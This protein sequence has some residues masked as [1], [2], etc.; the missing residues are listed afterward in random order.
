MSSW[1]PPPGGPL[2]HYVSE[3]PFDPNYTLWKASAGNL[4]G[5]MALPDEAKAGG[6][7]P[8]WISYIGTADADATA[9]Q[10][11]ALGGKIAKAPWGI[12]DGGRIAILQDPQGAIFAIYANPKATD[13][14]PA[15]QLGH[16]S[17]HELATTDINAAM[18]FYQQLF[19]WSL[20]SDMDMGPQGVYRMFG[21][22]G[23]TAFGGMYV[24]PP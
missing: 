15:P 9:R 13:T 11:E 2:P 14:P 21:P 20:M 18:T 19:G 6:T 1:L 23:S 16:A 17:W 22:E 12:A 7:P 4:G 5:L 10:A 24:K 3:A 8:S